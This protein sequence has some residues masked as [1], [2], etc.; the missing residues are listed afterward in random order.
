MAINIHTDPKF[1]KYLEW[2]SR[3]SKKTKT[4]VIKELVM[5]RFRLQRAAFRFGSLKPSQKP[6]S[7]KLQK[8]LKILDRDHDLD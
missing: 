3:H 7:K 1:E 6:S 4:D 5:E 8:E 2:L